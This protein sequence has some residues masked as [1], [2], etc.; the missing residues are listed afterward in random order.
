M[1]ATHHLGRW[2]TTQT[3]V[4]RV[5]SAFTGERDKRSP[6]Q[7]HPAKVHPPP[8]GCGLYLA[9]AA[10]RSALQ[11]H[12][13]M[14]GA[15]PPPPQPRHRRGPAAA[16]GGTGGRRG[17]AGPI[18]EPLRGLPRAEPAGLRCRSGL[19][20]V[21]VLPIPGP[22]PPVPRSRSRSRSAPAAL[23]PLRPPV[24]SCPARAAL[25]RSRSVAPAP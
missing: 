14:A 3:P 7:T 13:A 9:L 5:G 18:P 1:P 23:L 11:P 20:A 19:V 8:G 21:P 17:P 22:V 4:P 6:F 24:P 2:G 12:A 16:P 10:A 15:G 25:T